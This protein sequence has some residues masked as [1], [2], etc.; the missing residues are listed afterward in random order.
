MVR[1]EGSGI[2][3][4]WSGAVFSDMTYDW[5]RRYDSSPEKTAYRMLLMVM[6]VEKAGMGPFLEA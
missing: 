2:R 6:M 5:I 1:P 4:V 3:T